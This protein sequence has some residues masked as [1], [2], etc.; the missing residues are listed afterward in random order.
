MGK[1]PEDLRAQRPLFGGAIVASFPLRFQDVSDIREVP[2]NQEVFV[3]PTR[4]ESLIFELLE[5][6]TDVPDNGSA[7]WFLQDLANEQDAEGT[8]VL[9]QSGIVQADGEQFRNNRPII[10]T[11]VGQMAVSKG[12][13]GREAQNIVKVYLANLRLKNVATDVL[14]TAYEPLLINSLS[15]S[16]ASV[17][18]GLAIPA[19]ESG[20]MPM[21]E[22]FKCAVSSFNVNDWSLF[23]GVA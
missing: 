22:V 4:D 10:T 11:A 2:D 8:V 23:G 21:A 20:C 13:Q 14:I 19:A 3:D 18:A 16:A 15:E 9:E 12:R 17:G 6:K 5:L 1:M 7:T